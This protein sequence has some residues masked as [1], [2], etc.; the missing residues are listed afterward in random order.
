[1]IKKYL[2]IVSIYMYMYKNGFMI[3]SPMPSP[4]PRISACQKSE[5]GTGVYSID[6]SK[7]MNE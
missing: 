7:Y 6:I 1:M 2:D 4:P 3:V 5:Q